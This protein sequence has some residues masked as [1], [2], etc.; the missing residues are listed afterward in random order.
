M[1]WFLPNGKPFE[2]WEESELQYFIDQKIP[3]GK[4]LD[5]KRE[6][7]F[8]NDSDKKELISDIVSFANTNGGYLIFGIEEGEDKSPS[9]LCGLDLLDTPDGTIARINNSIRDAVE[10]RISNI[11]IRAIPLSSGKHALVIKIPNSFF[12]PHRSKDR[13][14]YAR[15]STGK[16]PLDVAELRNSFLQSETL[17]TA[18]QNFRLN[19][20]S[21]IV[22]GDTPILLKGKSLAIIHVIPL[23][24]LKSNFSIDIFKW[25]PAFGQGTLPGFKEH[26]LFP[27]FTFDGIYGDSND[28]SYT[29]LFHSGI[30]EATSY[31]YF[32]RDDNGIPSYMMELE[33]ITFVKN[34]LNFLTEKLRLT[35]PLIISISFVGIKNKHLLRPLDYDWGLTTSQTKDN[36]LL[37]EVLY[38]DVQQ[39]I[40]FNTT[41]QLIYPAL[42]RWWN[43]FDF[44][45][46]PYFDKDKNWV[47][48]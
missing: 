23:P 48:K 39:T 27:R 3:E 30:L 10:P 11:N 5:Y 14:F 33:I 19:R 36:I 35:E 38:E 32:T 46:S 6:L 40:D 20:I 16:Y 31:R 2:E 29:Q 4:E 17:R 43:A 12:S 15:N 44:P 18:S 21:Q 34:A 42:T 28:Y 1:D 7:N 41:A 13:H 47:A 24:A 8:G 45:R 26:P 22:N 37:P 9:T 25:V